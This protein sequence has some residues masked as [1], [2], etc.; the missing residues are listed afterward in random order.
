MS[1][2]SVLR[3]MIVV[4]CACIVALTIFCGAAYANGDATTVSLTLD[5]SQV[6]DTPEARSALAQYNLCGYGSAEDGSV[7][8]DSNTVWGNCGSL[9]LSLEDGGD[10][11]AEWGVVITSAFGPMTSASYLGLVYYGGDLHSVSGSS[12]DIHLT[13]WTHLKYIPTGPGLVVGDIT[14]ASS[15]LVW[16]A[17]CTNNG[18]PSARTWVESAED[19]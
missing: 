13:T 16:G 9:T 1:T 4:A 14:A 10:G 11:K 15:T 18:F 12:G 7:A 17:I 8:Q 6:P 19:E 3:R 2:Y 5:C